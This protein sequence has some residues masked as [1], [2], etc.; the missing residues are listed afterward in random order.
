[1][2]LK[3]RTPGRSKGRTKLMPKRNDRIFNNRKRRIFRTHIPRSETIFGAAFTAFVVAMGIWFASKADDYDPSERDISTDV[4]IA[5]KVEDKLWRAPL[6]RWGDT[7]PGASAA[8]AQTPDVGVF[9]KAI[10]ADGWQPSTRLQFFEAD[11]L[12]EKI[13]GQAPQY[14]NAGFVALHFVGVENGAGEEISIELYDMGRF[15]HALGIFAEQRDPDQAVTDEEPVYY[16]ETGI[17]AIGISGKYYFKMTGSSTSDTVQGKARQM[18]MAMAELAEEESA[19]PAAYLALRTQ[20]AVPFERIRF[21]KNDV[22]QFGFAKEFWFGAPDSSSDMRFF[23]HEAER[24]EDVLDLYDKLIE[25]NLYDFDMVDEGLD[26]AVMQ[27]KFLETYMALAY[28]GNMLYGV[29]GVEDLA[30]IDLDLGQLQ[31]SLN[32]GEY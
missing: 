9:P 23:V 6:Q 12:Y 20:L 2:R 17:G 14:I 3:G 7:M 16:Y 21:Q 24:A 1:M 4:L 10:L 28:S 29:E 27:H 8:V 32:A 26:Q 13:N 18:T 5:D 22:F 15:A 30:S 31:A 19:M 11:T 25:N